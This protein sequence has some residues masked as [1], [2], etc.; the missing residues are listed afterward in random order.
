MA[1]TTDEPEYLTVPELAELLRVKERKVY[2]L[3]SSGA[4]PCSRATG[5]LLFPA[6]E[7]RAW[8]SGAT[9]GRAGAMPPPILLGSHDPLL[10]WAIRASGCGLATYMDG[11]LDGLERFRRGEGVACGLHIHDAATGAWNLPAVEAACAGSESVLVAFA[12]RERGLVL[13]AGAEAPAS[14]ADLASLRIAPRQAQSGTDTLFRHL[15]AEAGT[16]AAALDLAETA[17]TETEAVETVATGRADAT[18]GLA[19]VARSFGLGFVPLVEERFDILVHRR[20]WFE[21]PMQAL[22]SFFSAQSFR[23]RAA[24]TG[25]YDT[26]A[27]GRVRWNG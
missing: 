26:G 3:A 6:A 20:A 12:T 11:S 15:L 23:D 8:I 25:G 19:C 13:R 4:V 7:V 27:L 24:R 21:P 2:D 14:L 22:L 5:K 9:P 16:D 18:F 1:E 17:R 10:D